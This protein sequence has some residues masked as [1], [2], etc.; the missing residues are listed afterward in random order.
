MMKKHI[1][2]MKLKS[3][4]IIIVFVTKIPGVYG[5]D[6]HKH[7]PVASNMADILS[8]AFLRKTMLIEWFAAN[9]ENPNARDLTYL[10]FLSKWR[11]D[12]KNRIWI[13]RQS[14]DKKIGRLYYVYP[15]ACEK[16]YLKMLVCLTGQDVDFV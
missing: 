12:E 6:I 15:L 3:I 13:P 11:W 14:R 8:Q 1:L 7:Y 5:Y 10:D 16:Y 2:E 9:R 4:W